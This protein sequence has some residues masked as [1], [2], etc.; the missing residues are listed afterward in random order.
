M[1]V[2][3]YT[4]IYIYIQVGQVE[5][6]IRSFEEIKRKKFWIVRCRFTVFFFPL[7]STSKDRN[8]HEPKRKTERTKKRKKQRKKEKKEKDRFILFLLCFFSFLSVFMSLFF[9]FGWSTRQKE[10]WCGGEVVIKTSDSKHREWD[11]ILRIHVLLWTNRDKRPII[12]S[13]THSHAL[14]FSPLP[15]SFSLSLSL[16]R[17]Y[18]V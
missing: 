15:L 10:K 18:G 4:Y 11:K 9:F 17:G 16:P 8:N 6:N 13:L 5:K 2:D 1:L 14:S 3:A 12:H 7:Y